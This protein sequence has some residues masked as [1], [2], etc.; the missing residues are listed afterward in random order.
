MQKKITIFRRPN[1]TNLPDDVYVEAKRRIGSVFT[2]GGDILKGLT[3]AEQKRLLPEILGISPTE[4]GWAKMVR[5]YFANLTIDVPQE[6]V[7]LDISTDE[8]GNPINVVDYIKWR[9]ASEHPHVAAEESINKGRYYISDPQKKE[10]EAVADTRRR[11]DAYKQLILLSEDNDRA[12]LVLKAFGVRTAELSEQQVE[13]ELE[14]LLE[15][16][17][18]E[19]IRVCTD[20]NLDTVALI[21]DCIEAG[22]LRKSGNT[23]LFGDEILGDDMEQAIRFLNLKKNSAMLLDIKAKLKAFS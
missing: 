2:K 9:F 1:T 10:Q 3:I 8:E 6:G 18:N 16:N 13:L 21:W 20:K 4:A 11:K 14:N 7:E 15:A 17:P 5:S 12:I 22:V 23:F 19:F